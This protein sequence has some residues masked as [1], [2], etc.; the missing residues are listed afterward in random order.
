MIPQIVSV[1]VFQRSKVK[2]RFII[3]FPNEWFN[4][5]IK[6]ITLQ[7][8]RIGKLSLST[9]AR[10][11]QGIRAFFDFI[12]ES[13]IQ[14]G[15]FKDITS[16]IAEEYMFWLLF[17]V[18]APS[19]RAVKVASLKHHLKFG[20][21]MDLDGF[22]DTRV[23]DGTENRML[24]TEDVLKSKVIDDRVMEQINKALETMSSE[25]MSL[26]E[27]IS[28]GLISL[29][30]ATGMRIHE[31]LANKT[32]H[33]SKDLTG[34]PILEVINKKTKTDRYIPISEEVVK[35]IHRVDKATKP[36]QEELGT[37]LI[38]VRK[39]KRP[40]KQ[41]PLGIEKYGQNT[42]RLHLE[43]FLNRFNIKEVTFHQFRHTIG[44]D[45]INNG[46]TLPEVMEY[47]GH[48]SAHFTRLYAQIRNDRFNKEYRDLGFIG[49]IQDNVGNIVDSEDKIISYDQRLMA[50]LPDGVCARPI[51]ENVIDCKKPNACLFCPKFITTPEFLEFHKDHLSR[52][53]ADK[54]RYMQETLIGTDYLLYETEKILGEIISQ[55]EDI[56]VS[57]EVLN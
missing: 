7:S 28:W 55:L 40:S 4:Y 12:E 9:I 2:S 54:E 23:F 25:P 8:I 37:N 42:A 35:V 19:T 45:L 6:D 52:I 41:N 14:L 26:D 5:T 15:T 30:K 17:N 29:T 50:Q 32:E 47:L 20:V 34:K 49:V 44:T 36:I 38:F 11:H 21:I 33:I 18:K 48:D 51:K 3:Q 13:Y 22:P 39:L 57:K 46:M 10:Y 16:R 1:C 56:L 27:T 31:A 24:Q 53:R 43:K